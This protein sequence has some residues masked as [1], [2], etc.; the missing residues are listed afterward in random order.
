[1]QVRSAVPRI[2]RN[3]TECD[4]SAYSSVA[5]VKFV[6][7]RFAKVKSVKDSIELVKFALVKFALVKFALDRSAKDRFAL[8]KFAKDRSAFDRF[9]FDKSWCDRSAFERSAPGSIFIPLTST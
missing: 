9:A 4:K 1:M 5:E 6:L 3:I 8:D 7:R 2:A